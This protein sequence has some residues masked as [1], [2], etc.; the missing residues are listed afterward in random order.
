MSI[1]TDTVH[2]NWVPA[3]GRVF[4][5]N[6]VVNIWFDYYFVGKTIFEIEFTGKSAFRW[7]GMVWITILWNATVILVEKS[8]P[9]W[10]I[11]PFNFIS[12]LLTCWFRSLLQFLFYFYLFYYI[13]HN[14]C[15]FILYD[16]TILLHCLM[17]VLLMYQFE[18]E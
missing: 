6:C 10:K 2:E 8:T 9:K 18:K 16:F 3:R 14:K 12:Y 17:E 1:S 4:E 11:I 7:K 13:S 15:I 5:W